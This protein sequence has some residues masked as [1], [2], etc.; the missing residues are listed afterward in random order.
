MSDE[1]FYN[2]REQF[3]PKSDRSGIN[4]KQSK[5][6]TSRIERIRRTKNRGFRRLFHLAKKDSGRKFLISMFL[7]IT[8]SL[9]LFSWFYTF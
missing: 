2:T 3:I 4:L 1:G 5:N 7:V 9:L 8:L 6:N